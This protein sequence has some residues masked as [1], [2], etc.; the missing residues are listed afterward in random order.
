MKQ[1]IALIISLLCSVAA[2]QD[3]RI[4]ETDWEWQ[5]TNQGRRVEGGFTR[6]NMEIDHPELRPKRC[7]PRV[8]VIER[9]VERQPRYGWVVIGWDYHHA[10]G[11]F[12]PRKMWLPIE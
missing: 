10:F 11:T 4:P 1:I 5:R 12:T 7:Q 3:Y 2:A 8:I 6:Y 9:V